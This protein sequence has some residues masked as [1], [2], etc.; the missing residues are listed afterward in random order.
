MDSEYH[1]LVRQS[2][3]MGTAFFMIISGSLKLVGFLMPHSYIQTKLSMMRIVI[4]RQ[5]F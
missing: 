3:M 5:P 2:K 1:Y 4:E